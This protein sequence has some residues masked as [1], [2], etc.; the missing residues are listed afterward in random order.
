MLKIFIKDLIHL[1]KVPLQLTIVHYVL[2]K[3]WKKFIKKLKATLN[4]SATPNNQNCTNPQ[5]IFL[6]TNLK[7][8]S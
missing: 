1:N 7:I 6:L 5:L 8:R 4:D 3:T 2:S